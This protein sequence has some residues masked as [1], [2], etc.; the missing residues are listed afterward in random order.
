VSL[1][2]LNFFFWSLHLAFHFDFG[3]HPKNLQRTRETQRAM[4]L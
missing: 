2:A 4:Y 3:G 1:P